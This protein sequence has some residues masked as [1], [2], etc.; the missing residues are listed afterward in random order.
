MFLAC[1]FKNCKSGTVGSFCDA[2]QRE[3][4]PAALPWFSLQVPEAIKEHYRN[5]TAL[6]PLPQRAVAAVPE[7]AMESK[8]SVE[9]TPEEQEEVC[10]PSDRH[11][12]GCRSQFE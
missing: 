1:K 11:Q 12:L 5:P 7:P 2:R 10:S 8:T 4:Q 9:A 3:R 6:L